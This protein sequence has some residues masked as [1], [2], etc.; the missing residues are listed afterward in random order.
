V[1]TT[2]VRT[3]DDRVHAL[4]GLVVAAAQIAAGEL[5]AAALPGARSPVTGFGRALIDLTPGPLVD[6]TVAL[7]EARDKPLLMGTLVANLAGGGVLASRLRPARPR[8]AL[9]L[10]GGHHLLAGVAAGSRPD[11]RAVPSVVAGAV[12]AAAGIGALNLL[13]RAP[14]PATRA[15][16]LGVAGASATEARQ[17]QRRAGRRLLA[18]HAAVA[19]PRPERRLDPVAPDQCFAVAGLA[20]LHTPTPDFYETDVTF[21]PPVLDAS[22]WRLEVGGMVDAPLTLSWE[23]LLAFGV[24]EHDATLVCVHNPVGGPRIGTARWSACRST[25]CS[26]AWASGPRPTSCWPAPSTASPPG[27]RSR[28]WP[29]TAR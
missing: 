27:S 9:A 15:L 23:A 11:A 26:T 21:P 17:L 7:A 25:A 14:G 28:C 1:P 2:P 24:E 12:G 8:A 3:P 29:T 13:A 16:L 19:L 5:A 6:V 18:R 20:P 4:D 10:V 22:T